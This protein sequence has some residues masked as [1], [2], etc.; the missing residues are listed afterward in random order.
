MKKNGKIINCSY[1]GKEKY[2]NKTQLARAEHHYCC[3]NCVNLSRRGKLKVEQPKSIYRRT[4]RKRKDGTIQRSYHRAI[5]EEYLGRKLERNE[6][7]HH[8]NGDKND[9]RIENLMLT[10]QKEH[11]RI[12]KEKLPKIKICKVCGKEFEPP[13]KHRGRNVICSKECWQKY[14]KENS[15]R[16]SKK[17]EQYDIYGNYLKTF[18]SIHEA[19]KS[20][21]KDAS[22]ICACCRGKHKYAYKYIWKYEEKK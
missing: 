1:C 16:Y 11:N 7:V 10:T 8:I 13:I 12:H 18:D 9:N 4:T 6:V 5:M 20:I 14:H 3:R 17:V 19:A 2:F 21:G 22:A 15:K